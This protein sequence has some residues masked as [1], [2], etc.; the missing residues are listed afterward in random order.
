ML[1]TF[2]SKV[3]EYFEEIPKNKFLTLVFA[4]ESKKYNRVAME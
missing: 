4:H 1:Y 2:I 3:N